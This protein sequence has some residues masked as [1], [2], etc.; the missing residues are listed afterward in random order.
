MINIFLPPLRSEGRLPLLTQH[1]LDKYGERTQ[2]GRDHNPTE[3]L[4]VR[5]T[6]TGRQRARWRRY[7]ACGVDH[8]A[9]IDTALIPDTPIGAAATS[10]LPPTGWLSSWTSSQRRE[11]LIES[12]RRA[13]CAEARRELLKIRDDSNEISSVR[14]RPLRKNTAGGHHPA[15]RA[16]FP[17]RI[18]SRIVLVASNSG[19]PA[20]GVPSEFW[21]EFGR[22][23][24]TVCRRLSS[25]AGA[26]PRRTP[27]DSLNTTRVAAAVSRGTVLGLP[28]RVPTSRLS[29]SAAPQIVRVG[30]DRPVGA[31]TSSARV[32]QHAGELTYGCPQPASS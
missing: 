8:A 10:R 26:A 6:T 25:S 31:R 16:R 13:V 27:L 18:D 23:R 4:Y 24:P 21:G 1:F 2:A 17:R 3:A 28:H 15:K 32:R 11:R 7:R 29:R 30:S 5:R 22:S 14:D 19:R 12:R 9:M 20:S